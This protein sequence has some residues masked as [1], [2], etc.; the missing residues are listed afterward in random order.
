MRG[1]AIRDHTDSVIGRIHTSYKGA[2][3]MLAIRGYLIEPEKDV[4]TFAEI[5]RKLRP[6]DLGKFLEREHVLSW[7]LKHTSYSGHGQ[8]SD[9]IESTS[10]NI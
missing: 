5:E 9:F 7:K 4:P 2:V 1:G 10:E 8:G 3:D 6:L